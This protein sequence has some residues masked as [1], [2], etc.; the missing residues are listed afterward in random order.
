MAST[1]RPSEFT[2]ETADVICE[3]LADGESL[4]SICSEDAM[5]NKATV[6]RWLAANKSFSDQYARAREVQADTLFDECLDIV[7][8]GRNDWVERKRRD[9]STYIALNDEAI[10][11]SRLRLDARKW[12]AGKLAPKK[13]GEKLQLGGDPDGAPVQLQIVTGVPRA[14]D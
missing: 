4:R 7:D 12:M 3:R 8:D 13:Y 9:G 1:G 6:F 5:P 10:S 11:R 14:G 2:Q